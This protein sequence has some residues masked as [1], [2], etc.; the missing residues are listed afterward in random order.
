MGSGRVTPSQ[1]AAFAAEFP[2]RTTM[3]RSE[4]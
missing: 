3:F 1:Q 2:E 4:T